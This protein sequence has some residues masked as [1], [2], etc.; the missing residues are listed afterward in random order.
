MNEL[1][2]FYKNKKVLVTGATGFKGS[3]LCSW[4]LKLGAKVYGIGFVPNKNKYLFYSLKLQNKI[5]LKLFDIRDL[6]KLKNFIYAAKPSII[7]HMAAQ[8][9]V[10]E[11]FNNPFLTFDVNAKGTLNVLE[12]SKKSKFVKSIV[13]ITSDKCYENTGIVKGYKETDK[14]GGVDPYS[15][16]KASAEL[17]VRS[18]R[19]S[20]YNKK[21]CGISS[22][23]AGNVI[24]GGDFSPERLIPDCVK[25]IRKRK[26]IKIRNPKFNRPWQFVLEPLN[27]YLVLAKKQY[28]NPSK[29]SSAWNFGPG[30]K[31]IATVKDV[32]KKIV[33][34][35]GYGSFQVK[36]SYK[37]SEHHNLQLDITKAKKI[38]KWKPIYDFNSSIKTTVEWYFRVFENKENPQKVTDYQIEQYMNKGNI[39]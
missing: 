23:R 28:E 2:R 22:V 8:P 4:L 12:A 10:Y 27:G 13:C 15:A 32:V 19:E 17:I 3:W 7:F 31:S 26:K 11:S 21:K 37:I 14:L 1:S 35:W 24:G 16:S 30:G 29:F 34:F 36:K 18:Y 25:F 39:F 9:I 6:K 20:I 5:S 38:L 33:N